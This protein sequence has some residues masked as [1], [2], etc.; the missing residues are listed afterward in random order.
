MKDGGG[1]GGSC[2]GG[3]SSSKVDAVTSKKNSQQAKQH[4]FPS[5][6]HYIWAAIRKCYPCWGLRWGGGKWGQDLSCSVN[7]FRKYLHRSDPVKMTAKISYRMTR[8]LQGAYFINKPDREEIAAFLVSQGL[9]LE[10]GTE[11]LHR[12]LLSMLC[13]SN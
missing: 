9:C 12:G 2:R 1:D 3:S 11:R 13:G 10:K 7:A 4:C 5:R 6:L 8:G